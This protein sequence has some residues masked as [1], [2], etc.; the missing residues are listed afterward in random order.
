MSTFQL[1]DDPGRFDSLYTALAIAMW[2]MVCWFAF[3]RAIPDEQYGIIF[4]GMALGL[5][6]VK[7]LDER[8]DERD[9]L[10]SVLLAVSAIV[11]LVLTIYM[12][13][14]FRAIYGVRVGTAYDY[15]YTMAIFFVFTMLYLVYRSFGST[16]TM[17]IIGGILYGFVGPYMPG[18]LFHGGLSTNRI[19]LVLVM[20]IEGFYG[21]LT[22]VV[23]RWVALFL[24][25]A[26]LLKG[27]GA[28]DLVFRLAIRTSR[29]IESGVA[30]TAVLASAIIGS[31]NGS[32]TANAGM[33]GSFTIPLM[34]RSGI[35]GET[36]GGI[37][38]VASTLGQVL[39]PVMGAAAFIMASLITGVTYFDVLVAGIVPAVILLLSTAVAVHFVAAR[40]IEPIDIEDVI[41]EPMTRFKLAIEG[42]RFGIP[43]IVLIWLLGIW[44]W[45]VI[46]SALYTV[47]A[48]LITGIG[49]PLIGTAYRDRSFVALADMS[50]TMVYRT[51]DGFREGAVIVAPVTIILAAINGVVDIFGVTGVP[52][53]ISLA[54]IDLSGGV[55]IFGLILTLIIC[56]VL[57]LG[58]PT[59]A[60]YTLVALLIAPTLTGQFLIPDLSAHY[61]VFY[62]AL[63]AGLTPPIATCPAVTCGIAGS[64]FWRTCW[65]SLKIAAPIFVI[66]FAFIY[67]PDLVSAE[68]TLATIRVMILTLAGAIVI[69]YGI[70]VPMGYPRLWEFPIRASHCCFGVIAMVHPSILLQVGA[71]AGFTVVMTLRRV[72]LDGR[73]LKSQ[74]ESTPLIDD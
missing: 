38:S 48:M 11:V 33:T 54:L 9:W 13:M 50:R 52:G 1:D 41:D 60:S 72:V 22:R 24:L 40:E 20:D 29:Y 26:G 10:N 57:G 31:V 17:I 44:Q 12:T 55:L 21:F 58:M 70:N 4:L 16:F 6:I 23:A 28:F 66:P 51:V 5:F 19:L 49:F 59:T 37:E 15:E 45:T 35:K 34:M 61:F 56:I 46:T 30:Q 64:N 53:A 14:E 7:E 39:P 27:F 69:I 18:I 2:L 3:T 63:L 8:L 67:H 71:L 42:V 47:V 36:A 62:A 68:F 25:F 74:R 43:L 65:A 32:Q 73:F